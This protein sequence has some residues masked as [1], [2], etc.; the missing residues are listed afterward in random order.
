MWQLFR[1]SGIGFV[2]MITMISFI[3][4]TII[5]PSALKQGDALASQV[6]PY[7]SEIMNGSFELF[8]G[9]KDSQTVWISPSEVPYWNDEAGSLWLLKDGIRGGYDYGDTSGDYFLDLQVASEG[10]TYQDIMTTPGTTLK[11]SV[12][13][14]GMAG[15][16][17]DFLVGP[18]DGVYHAT[19]LSTAGP[20]GYWQTFS[21]A[22]TVPDGQSTTRVGF[23]ATDELDN[24]CAVD[25]LQISVEPSEIVSVPEPEVVDTVDFVYDDFSNPD[26]NDGQKFA[27]QDVIPQGLTLDQI[28]VPAF[29]GGA[30]ITYDV[31][32]QTNQN[33]QWRTL[34]DEVSAD[35]PFTIN[36]PE[37]SENERVTSTIL[38][39]NQ[40]PA[41]FGLGD[42]IIYTFSVEY[43]LPS[44]DQHQAF[45]FY[46]VNK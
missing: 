9:S 25:N 23:R 40:V 4:T 26:D 20:I 37:L 24:T 10:M 27:I 35:E 12:D 19:R 8:N 5:Y 44:Y 43:P 14:M 42:Q 32:Y 31:Q 45:C 39:F 41:G 33:S 18:P 38:L 22:Y 29:M 6:M 21:G 11:W 3:L 28:A 16:S 15:E 46:G 17:A 7:P 36:A 30:G 1:I 13:F 2:K 34:Y